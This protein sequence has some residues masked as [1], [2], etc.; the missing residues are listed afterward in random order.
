LG[1]KNEVDSKGKLDSYQIWDE[2]KQK[3]NVFHLHK[4][5]YDEKKDINIKEQWEKALG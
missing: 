3:Y 5:Y 1:L 4:P 2:L